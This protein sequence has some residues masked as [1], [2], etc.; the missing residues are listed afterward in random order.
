MP[1]AKLSAKPEGLLKPKEQPKSKEL[2][3]S[4]ELL[5][6][7]R[8]YRGLTIKP[9]GGGVYNI[10]N[11]VYF[12]FQVPANSALTPEEAIDEKYPDEAESDE[13]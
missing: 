8:E 10:S 9:V 4:E 2:P 5:K 6:S 13:D 7:E 11:G 12:D 3:K 1:K